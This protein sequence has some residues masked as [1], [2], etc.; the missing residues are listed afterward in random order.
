MLASFRTARE[1]DLTTNAPHQAHPLKKE[2][3]IWA[4]R[5]EMRANWAYSHEMLVR[6]T[7]VRLRTTPLRMPDYNAKK[8][9]HRLVNRLLLYLLGRSQT[10][11]PRLLLLLVVGFVGL[12]DLLFL[13][14]RDFE[15]TRLRHA[16]DARLFVEF[17]EILHTLDT[18][19]TRQDVATLNG[20]GL[21][22]EAAI[23]GHGEMCQNRGGIRM[24]K[25]NRL[26]TVRFA[27]KS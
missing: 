17:V 1:G 7:D 4:C 26:S 23:H 10:L 9:T 19:S 15:Y 8:A 13:L 20:P 25:S 12:F 14:Q 5:D 2:P 18:F 24:V 27:G 3:A 21:H 22:L 6:S 16:N 11:R